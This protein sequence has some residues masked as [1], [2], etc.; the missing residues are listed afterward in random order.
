M[1]DDLRGEVGEVDV[2]SEGRYHEKRV[3]F[4]YKEINLKFDNQVV[5]VRK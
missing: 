4:R 2:V 3:E 1:V 5:C